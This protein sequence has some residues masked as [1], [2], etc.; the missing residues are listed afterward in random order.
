MPAL[1]H[2]LQRREDLLVGEIA[3]GAEEDECVGMRFAHG[4]PRFV[5]LLFAG[6]LFEVAA[7]LVAHRREQLVLESAS[8]R[9]LKRS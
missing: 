1:D 4:E 5:T 2:R 6:R 3:G 7:E 8:P 9:E